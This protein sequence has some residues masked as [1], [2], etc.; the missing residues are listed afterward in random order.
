MIRNLRERAELRCRVTLHLMTYRSLFCIITNTHRHLPFVLRGCKNCAWLFP[1][2]QQ[3]PRI[4][5]FPHKTRCAMYGSYLHTSE[6]RSIKIGGWLIRSNDGVSFLL[7][8]CLPTWLSG[9][10]INPCSL[11]LTHPSVIRATAKPWELARL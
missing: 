10:K 1:L 3:N 5:L 11:K 9:Q 7:L 2:R 4:H 8:P 6:C